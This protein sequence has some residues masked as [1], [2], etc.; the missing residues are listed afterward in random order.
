M[1]LSA[2]DRERGLARLEKGFMTPDIYQGDVWEV[3]ADHGSTY[4]VPAHLVGAEPD[5]DTLQDC[6]ESVIDTDDDGNPIA[7]LK[8]GVWLTRLSASGY[9]D[10]TDWSIHDSEDE[11]IDYLIDTYD[12]DDDDSDDDSEGT[13]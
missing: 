4:Y 5:T 10:C 6:V 11:A 8:S 2:S 12:D 3:S 13:R 9:M 7:E 1:T